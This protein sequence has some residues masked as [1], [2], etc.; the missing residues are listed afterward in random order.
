MRQHKAFSSGV[1]GC[2]EEFYGVASRS[3]MRIST[4]LGAA[5]WRCGGGGYNPQRFHILLQCRVAE[6]ACFQS[7]LPLKKP[8]RSVFRHQKYMYSDV[9][10]VHNPVF[11][12]FICSS[13]KDSRVSSMLRMQ[14]HIFEHL[15]RSISSLY[16]RRNWYGVTDN[17]SAAK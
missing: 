16:Q 12:P 10:F 11:A 17:K 7:Q 9:L 14:R 4:P 5:S 1:V 15:F 3:L 6:S 2:A 8:C 13:L